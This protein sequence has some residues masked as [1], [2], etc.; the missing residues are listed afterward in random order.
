MSRSGRIEAIAH[1]IWRGQDGRNGL[2]K[3]RDQCDIE[4]E[5]LGNGDAVW[6][7]AG[8]VEILERAEITRLREALEGAKAFVAA[9]MKNRERE[10]P[11]RGIT[12]DNDAFG[13]LTKPR[14]CLAMIEA[15]LGKET[16]T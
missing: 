12:Y 2:D 14:D 5:D 16:G 6:S 10:A 1:A 15:A 8:A 7:M 4:V 9:E 3:E 13:F 11:A